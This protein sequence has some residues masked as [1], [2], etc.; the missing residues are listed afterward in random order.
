MKRSLKLPLLIALALGST[1]LLAVD[2]GQIQVKS[3][4]GQPLLAEI[5]VHAATPEELQHLTAQLASSDEFARAGIAGGRTAI[6]LHFSV[7]DAAGGQRVIRITS[8]T[9]VEDPFLDL[10]IE[11][12]AQSGKSVRE[13]AILLDP[14]GSAAPAALAAAPAPAPR[15]HAP[16]ARPALPSEE[17]AQTPAR[18]VKV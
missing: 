3:A 8:T 18:R 10:L 2:L 15:A 5:P 13:F 16:G 6:P 1:P 4:L 9:P 12:N 17:P 7:A 14:P 11:V